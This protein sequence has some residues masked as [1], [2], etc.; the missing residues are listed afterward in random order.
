M[1]LAG[2][3][4][5]ASTWILP[6]ATTYVTFAA[7]DLCIASSNADE[8]HLHPRLKLVTSIWLACFVT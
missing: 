8:L 2:E 7:T 3:N 1:L 4:D 5:E 6:D